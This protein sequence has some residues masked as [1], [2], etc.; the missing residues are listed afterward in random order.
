MVNPNPNIVQ[1][2]WQYGIC[3]CYKNPGICMKVTSVL[4]SEY[5]NCA[6]RPGA[7]CPA[8]P[9]AMERR[10]VRMAWAGV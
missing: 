4:D 8:S 5:L 1:N 7:A 10:W 6:C 9:A 2:E 3:E